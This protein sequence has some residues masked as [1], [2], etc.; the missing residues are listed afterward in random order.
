MDAG[1]L[2]SGLVGIEI[3]FGRVVAGTGVET[4]VFD[5]VDGHW[6]SAMFTSEFAVKFEHFLIVKYNILPLLTLNLK[7][8]LC[9]R[10]IYM[11]RISSDR[12]MT[13]EN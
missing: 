13:Q 12:S 9:T 2:S 3:G 8:P 11:S 5:M 6:W 7:L 10:L 1:T 4:A